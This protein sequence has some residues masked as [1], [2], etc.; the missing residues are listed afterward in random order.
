PYNGKMDNSADNL[1]LK[2]PTTPIKGAAPF[3]IIDKVSYSDSS[4]WPGADGDGTSL[5]RRSAVAYG[6][7]PINWVAAA[8]SS[9]RAYVAGPGVTISSQPSDQTV[10]A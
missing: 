4:P 10:L 2:K 7:D 8:P 6:N 3:V 5:Q 1:E 9:A